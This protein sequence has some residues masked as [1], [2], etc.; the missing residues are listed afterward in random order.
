MLTISARDF[1]QVGGATSLVGPVFTVHG[2]EAAIEELIDPNFTDSQLD[3]IQ[4]ATL[5]VV[6]SLMMAVMA[7]SDPH[8]HWQDNIDR[9]LRGIVSPEEFCAVAR[10]VRV[11]TERMSLD[12]DPRRDFRS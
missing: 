6:S 5:L 9:Y 4:C 10:S 12:A 2:Q 3:R 1:V 11:L 7:G 8:R